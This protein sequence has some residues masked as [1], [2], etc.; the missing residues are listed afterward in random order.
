M[1]NNELKKE[2]IITSLA[3]NKV[4]EKLICKR[5]LHQDDKDD[6]TMII[7]ESLLKINADKI[8][9]LLDR[10]KLMQY[11]VRMI[12]YQ[13]IYESSKF[14]I[15]IRRYKKNKISMVTNDNKDLDVE[16]QLCLLTKNN[17]IND[18]LSNYNNKLKN[19]SYNDRCN[20]IETSSIKF[21]EQFEI[22]FK[23]KYNNNNE[24]E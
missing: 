13:I 19:N 1:I 7:Y 10:D 20:E 15:E 24:K 18:N 6:L 14:E 5:N 23:N 21:K 4:V 16:D 2:Q 22:D 17:N 12:K 3:T 11:I 8:V 9:D